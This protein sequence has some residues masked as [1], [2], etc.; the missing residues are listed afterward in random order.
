MKRWIV[1]DVEEMVEY[2]WQMGTNRALPVPQISAHRKDIRKD[3]TARLSASIHPFFLL[4]FL[5]VHGSGE[6]RRFLGERI[7]KESTTRPGFVASAHFALISWARIP[8][9]PLLNMPKRLAAWLT[10][11]NQ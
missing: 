7:L 5:P 11:S 8:R 6:F 4:P 1:V 10:D 9:N 2:I 3:L